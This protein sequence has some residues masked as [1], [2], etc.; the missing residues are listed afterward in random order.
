MAHVL[1]TLALAGF[2]WM[3]CSSPA[4]AVPVFWAPN[5]HWYDVVLLPNVN[6]AAAEA[7]RTTAGESITWPWTT[8][9]LA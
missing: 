7:S 6:W 3:A 1:R 5:N 2:A 9:T 4:A 8:A